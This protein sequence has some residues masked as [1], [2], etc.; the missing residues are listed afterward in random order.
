MD[1]GSIYERIRPR[2]EPVPNPR[3]SASTKSKNTSQDSVPS[4]LAPVLVSPTV[5]G[6]SCDSG[7]PSSSCDQ[8]P[9]P[10]RPP[11]DL[12]QITSPGIRL[13]QPDYALSP[14]IRLT[15][16]IAMERQRRSSFQVLFKHI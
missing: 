3:L 2:K 6:S 9:P 7:V 1:V 11:P 12:N 16:A 10:D 4:T 15:S 13:S 8:W 5:D 14:G